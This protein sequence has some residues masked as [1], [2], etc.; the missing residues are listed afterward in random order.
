MD[1]SLWMRAVDRACASARAWMCAAVP[2]LV[3]ARGPADHHSR[4]IAATP[5]RLPR[6]ETRACTPIGPRRPW[7]PE[8]FRFSPQY[9]LWS[10]G[11]AKSRWL[12]IPKGRF[13]DGSD[14]DVWKFPVGTKLWK[15]FAFGAR[16]ETR[17]IERTRSGW[18]FAT[19][20]WNDDESEAVLAPEGGIKQS[21]PSRTASV[22]PSRHAST[23]ARVTK[24]GPCACS[25]SRRCSC[26]RTAIPMRR[27][28]SR[29]RKARSISGHSRHVGSCAACRHA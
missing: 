15:E 6:C 13:I 28:P 2:V 3:P 21:V 20:V 17:F 4:T 29:C 23:A 16:A 25:A 5:G 18:Q 10:D 22:T 9:P 1:P 27:M 14:P 19:Y 8:T 26:R 11:A 24:P 12:H 7:Q